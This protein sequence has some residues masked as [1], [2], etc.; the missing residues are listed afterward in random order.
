MA[1]GL[2]YYFVAVAATGLALFVLVSLSWWE[3]R[4]GPPDLPPGA[5]V[6]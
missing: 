1:A 2:D 4:R 6:N 5:P 3:R